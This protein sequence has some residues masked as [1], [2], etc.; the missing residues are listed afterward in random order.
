[1]GLDSLIWP[2][3][4]FP[5]RSTSYLIQCPYHYPFC[6][7][8]WIKQCAPIPLILGFG[9]SSPSRTI[10]GS[11]RKARLVAEEVLLLT[12]VKKARTGKT[13]KLING[14]FLLLYQF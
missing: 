14:T 7:K 12:P 8:D 13:I 6:Y 5:F 4:F 11:N 3:K 9:G 1:M 2:R 10:S